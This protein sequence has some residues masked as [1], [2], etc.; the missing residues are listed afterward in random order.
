LNQKR[1]VTDERDDEGGGVQR[2]WPLRRL[3]DTRWPW[4]SPFE[5]HP[6]NGREWLPRSASGIDES[7]SVEVIALLSVH[8]SCG[9]DSG[10]L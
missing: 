9:E 4:C 3:V 10:D 6:R 8:R 1:R 7:P 5:Q 2:W